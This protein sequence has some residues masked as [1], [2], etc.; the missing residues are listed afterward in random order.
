[1]K[2][3]VPP[4]RLPSFESSTH[5]GWSLVGHESSPLPRRI[6]AWDYQSDLR[7][8]AGLSVDRHRICDE[9]RL[10]RASELSVLVIARSTSTKLERVVASTP[11]PPLDRLDLPLDITLDGHWLGGRLILE[12]MVVARN[13]I[14]LGPTSA[15]IV[16]AILWTDRHDTT[17]EG[18]GGMFPTDSEDFRETRPAHKDVPWVLGVDQSDMDSLFTAAVRL[19][20]NSGNGAVAEMLSNAA[21]K[22][23]IKI[24][25]VLE[26]DITRQLAFIA[27]QSEE[28]VSRSV[29]TDGESL[30][31]V[32]RLLISK[33]WPTRSVATLALWKTDHPDRLEKDIQQFVRAF[34]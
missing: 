19:T 11:I 25:R 29:V 12:T 17:L 18:Q 8:Q 31:D 23:S 28:V 9:A 26:L 16:G 3:A 14:P 20:L 10:D 32:L 24:A 33:I 27:I 21:S 5:S 30:G 22:D 2:I 4:F 15:A 7:L 34:S 13:P 6:E 1:M